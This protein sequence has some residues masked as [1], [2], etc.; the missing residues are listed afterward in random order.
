VVAALADGAGLADAA[1]DWRQVGGSVGRGR[2]D[3]T[4][5]EA[6]G[7]AP[8]R[9]ARGEG[10][11]AGAALAEQAAMTAANITTATDAMP[12]RVTTPRRPPYRYVTGR[13]R[14]TA[15]PPESPAP[16]NDI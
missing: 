9:A 13:L 7:V 8:G 5:P 3:L 16:K 6:G 15:R 1:A 11:F 2:A 10:V 4:G 12:E 14:S